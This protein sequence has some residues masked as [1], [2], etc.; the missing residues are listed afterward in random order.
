M[1]AT[2]TGTWIATMFAAMIAT[3]IVWYSLAI[4]TIIAAEITETAIDTN[5]ILQV[6]RLA[7]RPLFPERPFFLL[8][9][10]D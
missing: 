3:M 9:Q 8:D 2:I 10:D 5:T 6:V 1:T 7:S 4:A